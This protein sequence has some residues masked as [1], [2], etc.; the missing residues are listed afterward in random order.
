MTFLA[1]ATIVLAVI[2]IKSG[3]FGHLL[4]I[5]MGGIS[6]GWN[7]FL[8]IVAAIS[9][10]VFLYR[11]YHNDWDPQLLW[12]DEPIWFYIIGL[13]LLVFAFSKIQFG[14]VSAT[15]KT[16]SFWTQA[17]ISAIVLTTF[18]F[19]LSKMFPDA[20]LFNTTEG[21]VHLLMYYL[22]V[23]L[24]AAVAANFKGKAWFINTALIFLMFWF[25]GHETK[26]LLDP[27]GQLFTNLHWLPSWGSTGS[28]Q[29]AT[30]GACSISEQLPLTAGL[31]V[32]L[33]P[34]DCDLKLAYPN[35]CLALRRAD[36]TG[37]KQWYNVCDTPGRNTPAPNNI[38]YAYST[39]PVT[40]FVQRR[41]H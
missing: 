3:W 36:W 25:V 9:G 37:D 5:P 41:P 30:Y 24:M 21:R 23:G 40:M 35:Q 33:N 19:L 8:K 16:G 31:V 11:M 18:F 14:W 13:A 17:L 15:F 12:K 38:R 26:R 6:L 2:A 1:I 34:Q 29:V 4:H 28:G 32:D 22:L 20:P 10:A 39:S 27:S 7:G